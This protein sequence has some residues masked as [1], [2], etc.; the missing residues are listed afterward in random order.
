V[1]LTEKITTSSL[2][3]TW[4]FLAL[5]FVLLIKTGYP[6]LIL[7]EVGQ[8][9]YMHIFLYASPMPFLELKFLTKLKFFNF[10]FFP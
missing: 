8:I 7:L 1:L 9:I 4:I 2:A 10:T 5:I 3:I 6:V